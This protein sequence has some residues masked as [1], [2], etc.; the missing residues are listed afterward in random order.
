MKVLFISFLL[1]SMVMLNQN[2]LVEGEIS[3]KDIEKRS[4]KN[5]HHYNDTEGNYTRGCSPINRCRGRDDHQNH[6][7]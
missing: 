5:H 4:R 1:I 7:E 6:N 3:F 2:N